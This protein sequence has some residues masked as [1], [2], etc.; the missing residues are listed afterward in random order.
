MADNG[1]TVVF[2]RKIIGLPF[3]IKP[4]VG[5]PGRRNVP[6]SYRLEQIP[7]AQPD[8]AVEVRIHP[9]SLVAVINIE[10]YA[11]C[12]NPDG[13]IQR[14][15][16]IPLKDK[17]L[18]MV[19]Q[20]LVKPSRL[21]E[22]IKNPVQSAPFGPYIFEG[23]FGQLLNIPVE[24]QIPAVPKIVILQDLPD[25]FPVRLKVVMPPYP[26]VKIADDEDPALPGNVQYRRR[27]KTR[28]DNI[29]EETGRPSSL[30]PA[31]VVDP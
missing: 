11:A 24:D 5:T 29:G 4:A 9:G 15:G 31:V 26:H 25:N 12:F 2:Y 1:N 28:A 27:I 23:K 14:I 22:K 13:V 7:E 8:K 20:G 18:V 3:D 6:H 21:S 17:I 19:S 10:G 16:I 30:F